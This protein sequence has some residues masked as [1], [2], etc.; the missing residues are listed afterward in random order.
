MKNVNLSTIDE[1]QPISPVTDTAV[2]LE[3][4]RFARYQIPLR[5]VIDRTVYAVADWSV[6]GFAVIGREPGQ[7][8]PD[9]PKPVRLAFEFGDYTLFLT[10]NARLRRF[11]PE[12]KRSGFEIIKT[13]EERQTNVLRYLVDAYLTGEIVNIGDVIEVTARKTDGPARAIPP[14]ET[15]GTFV[16]KARRNLPRIAGTAFVA[17]VTLAL[18]AYVGT[19]IYR[20]LYIRD[21]LLAAVEVDRIAVTATASGVVS[22]TPGLT[23]VARGDKLGTIDD[24]RTNVSQDIVSPCDCTVLQ[25]QV[26]DGSFVAEAQPILSLTEN[27]ATPYIYAS[28]DTD[29]LMSIYKGATAIIE[30]RDG[31]ETRVSLTENPP[32]TRAGS[33]VGRLGFGVDVAI[34]S[35]RSDLTTAMVGDP[36][37][38]RFD[39]SGRGL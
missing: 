2:A 4:R 37:R 31:T 23:T 33:T 35:G 19:G 28:V 6:G 11:D 25:A 21:A 17:A 7:D 10:V 36:V 18:L 5:V 26:A 1:I 34:V 27:A 8:S 9:V 14:E 15:G 24:R 12:T 16:E 13:D 29:T 3:Q 39:L 38:L 32:Q 22:F 30:Y 20:G